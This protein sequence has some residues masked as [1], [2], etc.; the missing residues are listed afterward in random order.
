[1]DCTGNDNRKTYLFLDFQSQRSDQKLGLH[2]RVAVHHVYGDVSVPAQTAQSVHGGSGSRR[3][4]GLGGWL[5]S[6]DDN[7]IIV[8]IKNDRQSYYDVLF[9]TI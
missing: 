2:C 9:H 3:T 7:F 5:K 4:M 8:G 1:M 6:L